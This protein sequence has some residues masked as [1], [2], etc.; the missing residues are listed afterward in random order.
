MRCRESDEPRHPISQRRLAPNTDTEMNACTPP[1][2]HS[3]SARW[4]EEHQLPA[5]FR[6]SI[7]SPT[8]KCC[9]RGRGR[10]QLKIA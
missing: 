10:T 2:D 9:P 1:A 5:A 7:S 6:A 4:Q 8:P 3:W